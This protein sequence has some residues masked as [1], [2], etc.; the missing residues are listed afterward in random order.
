MRI[1]YLSRLCTDVYF[2]ELV[3][4]G[5]KASPVARRPGGAA[6]VAAPVLRALGVDVTVFGSYTQ[7]DDAF[8]QQ[9]MARGIRW[10]MDF[11]DGPGAVNAVLPGPRI[12]RVMP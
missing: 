7:D 8:R 3:P 4:E 12:L 1:A 9:A 11:Q 5:G 10:E 2:S 6:V